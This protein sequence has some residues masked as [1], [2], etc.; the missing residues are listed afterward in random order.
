MLGAVGGLGDRGGQW[1]QQQVAQDPAGAAQEMTFNPS[2]VAGLSEVFTPAQLSEMFADIGFSRKEQNP[3]GPPED[4]SK[5]LEQAVA[6]GTAQA[7]GGGRQAFGQFA[8]GGLVDRPGYYATGGLGPSQ[9]Q[10]HATRA[11]YSGANVKPAIKPPGVHLINSSVPGRTDRIPMRAKTGSFVLPADVVS[12]FGQGNTQAGAKMWGDAIAHSIGP[13]G[14]QSAIRAR[15]MRAPTLGMA[16]LGGRGGKGARGFAE[17]G[18]VDDLTPIVTAGGEAL[19]DPEIVE[20]LGGGDPELGKK[21]LTSSMMKVRKQ[22][23]EHLKSLPRPA[24]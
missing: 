12:G 14:I 24:Q 21:K 3:A 22:V 8:L 4:E 13:M 23:I 10:S 1:I 2:I 9:M 15:A 11:H 17:G 18:D 6:A 20:A 7:M 16:G 19:V 5:G